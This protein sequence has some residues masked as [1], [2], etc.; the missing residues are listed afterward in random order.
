MCRCTNNQEVGLEAATLERVRNSS[1][2]E[3]RRADNPTGQSILPKL[4][5]RDVSRM[6]GERRRCGEAVAEAVV[7]CRRV[8]MPERVT[9]K[10]GAN[11]HHRKPE[12]SAARVIRGGLVGP[13]GRLRRRP[14]MDNR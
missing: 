2:V 13:K 12:G 14:P 5:M 1:L 6:V 8:R 10:W 11:P 4:R 7:E 3:C 9:E